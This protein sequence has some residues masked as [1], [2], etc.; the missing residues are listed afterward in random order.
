[1]VSITQIQEFKKVADAITFNGSSQKE[2]YAW[3]EEVLMRFRYFSQKKKE[4]SVVKHYILQMTG[5]SDAQTARLIARKKKSGKIFNS[6]TKRNTFP[7]TYTPG[8]VALLIET[9]KA[10][11]RLSG[12]ATKRIFQ[13]MY[14]FF[15]DQKFQRLK[16][17]SVS[18]I[19]NLRG[20]RQYRSWT[21]FFT[22]T[23]PTAVP[24]G[25]RRKPDPQGKPGFL[26]VDTVH[27]G[28]LDKEKGVYHIN[29]V[30]EVTQWELVGAVEKISEYY[31]KPLLEDLIAQF[32]FKII[33]FH[34]DNGSEYI[35]KI[36]AKLLHKLLI[37][38]TKSRSRHCNDN[39]LVEGK[40]GS[41]IRKH[42][43]YMHIPQSYAFLINQFYKNY[44]NRYL[45]YH[46][47]CGFATTIISENGKQK[48]VYDVY[49]TPYEAL[50]NHL[51]A[52][53][54]LKDDVSFGT[55]DTIAYEKSDN[56]Y[57][58]LMQKVKAELFNN[59]RR[60]LRFPTTRAVPISGSSVD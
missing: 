33:N 29:I 54:F 46:R 25:E 4:K 1:M 60:R 57:A 59:F 44:F 38:Q 24:I 2:K 32:P 20:T 17:I 8:D 22:K 50:K 21:K 30:D 41:I 56:E 6:S 3:I 12:K 51:H 39:A 23:K 36:A 40:N 45:N 47:P 34:S 55:L 19:Y 53:K 37:K 28:D 43:G 18:H 27:Q 35:N 10:H 5:Y 14:N 49:R 15:H 52:E 42:M 16:N 13:R 48:K 9:D 7:R 26:R 11:D 58:A 31:L